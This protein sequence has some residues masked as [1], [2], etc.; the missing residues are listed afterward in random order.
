MTADDP[1]FELDRRE[2]SD[3]R[4]DMRSPYVGA[5]VRILARFDGNPLLYREARVMREQGYLGVVTKYWDDKERP[6]RIDFADEYLYLSEDEFEVLHEG[7]DT[8]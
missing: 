5:P 4:D 3:E 1:R 7:G 8:P 6:W 2:A